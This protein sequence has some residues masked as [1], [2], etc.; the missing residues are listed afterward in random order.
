LKIVREV[1]RFLATTLHMET[2]IP[3]LICAWI[4]LVAIIAIPGLVKFSRAFKR[5][6]QWKTENGH[7]RAERREYD[8]YWNS[9]PE[10][11]PRELTPREPLEQ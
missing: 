7:D 2:P 1:R 3:V 4:A 5:S 9:D 11:T 10:K 6:Q 8:W